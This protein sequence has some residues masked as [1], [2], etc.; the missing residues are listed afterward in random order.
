MSF[1]IFQKGL[2]RKEVQ[3]PNCK[4]TFTSY[5]D[6]DGRIVK[7]DYLLRKIKSLVLEKTIQYFKCTLCGSKLKWNTKESNKTVK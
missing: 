6:E 2:E 5:I 7:K 1:E 4:F 3:C